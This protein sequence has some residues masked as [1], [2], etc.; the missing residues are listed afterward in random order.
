VAGTGFQLDWFIKSLVQ[1]ENKAVTPILVD[2]SGAIQAHPNSTFIDQNSLSKKAEERSTIYR[3]MPNAPEQEEL[4][5]ALVSLK[6]TPAA[7]STF[8][9]VIEG[10]RRVVSVAYLPEIDWYL[11][12]LI[13]LSKTVHAAQFAPLA[14]VIVFALFVLVVAITFLI[15]RTILTPLDRLATSAR[16]VAGGDFTVRPVPQRQDEIGELT[17]T[18]NSMLDTIERTTLEL[19]QHSEGLEQRVRERTAELEIE[20]KERQKAELTAQQASQ[21]KSE[22]LA[23]MSHEIRTPMN[24]ILGFSEILDTRIQDP[25]HKEYV[26]AIHSSGKSLLR[27]INDI[28]DLSKVEAGKLR[29]EYAA[30]D[31][32]D[33][34]KELETLFSRKVE[35][36]R[37]SLSLEIEAGFPKA[38]V[39]DET[40]LRQVLLNLVGNAIKFTESGFVQLSAQARQEGPSGKLTLVFEVR[41]SGIGIPADQLVSISARSSNGPDKATP[42]TAGPGWAWPSANGWLN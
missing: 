4:R 18:F 16:S 25:R 36:K 35:E 26:A 2:P 23:N 29:L 15:N 27:L 24:A 8:S 7:V 34:L 13:D 9:F 10:Q 40:R 3:L 38:V 5:K 32:R 33:V 31:A 6:T 17:R 42:S 37:L 12:T 30:V 19:K 11:L 41:D 1:S 22:F 21:A 20:V 14:L 28:L 39:I